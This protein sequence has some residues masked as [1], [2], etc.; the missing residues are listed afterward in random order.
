[1]RYKIKKNVS[2]K[3][4]TSEKGYALI[5]VLIF[6]CLGTLVL[7]PLLSYMTTGL[8]VGAIYQENALELYA[9]DAGIND[10]LWYTQ[11]GDFESLLGSIMV[12]T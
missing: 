4:R 1:M 2:T 11:Y 12:T 3:S 7:T 5:V 9:A 10:S 8:K 6:L